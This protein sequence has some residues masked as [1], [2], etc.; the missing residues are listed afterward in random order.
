MQYQGLPPYLLMKRDFWALFGAIW[1]LAGVLFLLIGAVLAVRD[2]MY[3]FP[4]VGLVLTAVGAAILRRAVQRVRLE[5]YL[6]R[7]GLTGEGEVMAVQ[8]TTMR[9]NKRYQ[10]QIHYRYSDRM[11]N[12]HR[13]RSGYLEPQEAAAWGV[14]AKG[15]VR[16]D[17][18]APARSI[19]VGTPEEL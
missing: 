15:V 16:F 12:E 8:E 17:P 10:W 1:V 3:A 2:G 18:R 11:G 19:W 13:G 14:G 7:E 4:V 9:Y 5:Q 6:R